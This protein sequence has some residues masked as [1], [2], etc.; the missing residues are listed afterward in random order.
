LLN[1]KTD[2]EDW[3]ADAEII[4]VFHTNAGHVTLMIRR[5][6]PNAMSPLAILTGLLPGI[7]INT[8]AMARM[9]QLVQDGSC[10]TPNEHGEID[11]EV[12]GPARPDGLGSLQL[13]R[14][15]SLGFECR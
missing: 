6:T 13:P 14:N 2:A 4:A 7:K 11:G 9:T 10:L 15:T 5:M 8:D 1:L 12:V 3:K